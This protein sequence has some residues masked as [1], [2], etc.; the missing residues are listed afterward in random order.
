MTI[1]WDEWDKKIDDSIKI[2]GDQTDEQLASKL[3]SLT[4]LT[5]EEINEICPKPGDV[6]KLRRLLKI[7][8]S[9]EEKNNK[10]N[11]IVSNIEDFGGIIV[12]ILEKFI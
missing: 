11:K 4:R 9:A 2:A 6:D 3:S 10:I 8:K 1:N 5:D 12:P 7:V